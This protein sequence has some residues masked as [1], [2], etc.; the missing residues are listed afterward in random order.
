MKHFAIAALAA[1]PA[2]AQWQWIDWPITQDGSPVTKHFMTYP[3][4]KGSISGS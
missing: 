2:L 3:T 4:S 1:A